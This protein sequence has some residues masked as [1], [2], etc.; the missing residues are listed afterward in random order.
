MH[1]SSFLWLISV[2]AIILI[3]KCIFLVIICNQLTFAGSNALRKGRLWWQQRKCLVPQ[4]CSNW[5]YLKS[6]Q[7][8]WLSHL[9]WTFQNTVVWPSRFHPQLVMVYSGR[10]AISLVHSFRGKG[11]KFYDAARKCGP[12]LVLLLPRTEKRGLWLQKTA[13]EPG[14]PSGSPAAAV[15]A[16]R[17]SGSSPITWGCQCWPFIRKVKMAFLP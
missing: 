7:I 9:Q 3:K 15:C 14:N 11:D 13:C 10:R 1:E 12:V 16:Q 6:E 17:T 2:T 8:V 4:T 5:I